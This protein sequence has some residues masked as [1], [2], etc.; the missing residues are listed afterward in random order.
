MDFYVSDP[1]YQFR[2]GKTDSFIITIDDIY[3][4]VDA[5]LQIRSSVVTKWNITDVS[6]YLIRGKGTRYINGNGEYDYRYNAGE[7]PLLVTQWTRESLT[8][9]V[10]TYRK[11]QGT[12]IGEIN[13]SFG[14]NPIS[15]NEKTGSWS[16]EVTREPKSNK[17][18]FN[19]FIYPTIDA[20]Y[21]D[22]TT[23][24]LVSAVRYTD[25]LNKRPM[26]VSTGNMKLGTDQEGRTIFYS[27]GLTASNMDDLSGVDVKSNSRQTILAPM[28]VGYLQRIRNG[29]LIDTYYLMGIANAEIGGTMK[30]YNNDS[31]STQRVLFQASADTEEQKLSAEA[32]DLAVAVYFRTNG[33][34]GMELRSKY[35]YLTDQGYT[36]VKPGEL[37]ELDFNLGDVTEVSGIAFVSIGQLNMKIDNVLIADQT[38]DDV[39]D[40]K[41]YYQGT[42]APKTT[43][44]RYAVDTG[45]TGLLRLDL[46]TAADEAALN[47]G[48]NTPVRMTISF[49]DRKGNTQTKTYDDITPYIQTGEGFEAGGTDQVRIL[50]PEFQ[51]VRWVSF[52]PWDD[53]DAKIAT[54]K[55]SKLT[56]ASD[57]TGKGT[58]KV[59]NQRINEESPARVVLTD[60]MLIGNPSK[61]DQ[62]ATGETKNVTVE[63]GE[64]YYMSVKV[65][66]SGEGYD[67]TI[68][69][70]DPSS[71]TEIEADLSTTHGYTDEY[72]Q[73][74]YDQAT[75]AAQS[76]DATEAEKS[77]ANQVAELVKAM[78]ESGGTFDP[79]NAK[80]TIAFKLPRN[81]TSTTKQYRLKVVSVENPEASFTVD[82]TVK[83]EAD[84]LPTALAAW[85]G[86]QIAVTANISGADGKGTE[87]FNVNKGEKLSKMLE[88]NGSLLI[89]SQFSSISMDAAL[90][91]LDP[92]SD[93]TGTASTSTIYGYTDEQ[94]AK[95]KAEA[96]EKLISQIPE[97]AGA[98][99]TLGDILDKAGSE[100]NAGSFKAAENQ[101]E[102]DAPLNYSDSNAY[103][104]IVV[105]DAESGKE[106]FTL[107][108]TVKA[109][110][111][112]REAV[113]AFN[114][115]RGAD[116]DY[117]SVDAALKKV[118]ADLSIYTDET[119][120]AVTDAVEAVERGKSVD[121]QDAVDAMA[122][123]IEDAVSGLKKK[124]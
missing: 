75:E 115:A 87:T 60:I 72:L 25:T 86:D 11:L 7:T 100:D 18:T 122:K 113:E 121:E 13:I 90:Y 64:A 106:L 35:V 99:K 76:A 15:I 77:A 44:A 65:Y 33:P 43:P 38:A 80:S 3:Q 23:Y 124:P 39:I 46:E 58:T 70:I 4:M 20:K 112:L 105:T 102:F 42:I 69:S 9:D 51:E 109:D 1:E 73:G 95:Y 104:R 91:S 10:E 36:S 94:I 97:L 78:Q 26:Q 19:L 59:V 71:N 85:G 56:A 47:S 54:W 107:D 2:A 82:I 120:K 8:K 63:S 32:N 6:V 17:D 49:Y 5:K 62:V 66:G 117:T 40:Q 103:Y 30:I 52:E 83:N 114:Q 50:I 110:N 55:L 31:R 93:A 28:S 53:N 89:R 101:I 123:A 12:G 79:G 57:L 34:T 108:I 119:A 96:K 61:G 14:A 118:P 98:A 24:S 37:F 67:A 48:T 41:W 74:L 45:H 111:A 84:R 27:L 116:A 88:P 22:P 68:T 29:V 21:A 16:A 81:F 92:V